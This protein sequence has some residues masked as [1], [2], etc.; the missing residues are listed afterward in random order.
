MAPTRRRNGCLQCPKPA[1]LNGIW[2]AWRIVPACCLD[3]LKT[4]FEVALLLLASA[5]QG[6]RGLQ[7]LQSAWTAYEH[8]PWRRLK[9]TLQ[10]CLQNG[11]LMVFE[12]C[13]QWCLNDATNGASNGTSNDAWKRCFQICLKGAWMVAEAHLKWHL[14]NDWYGTQS[15]L[16]DGAWNGHLDGAWT[17]PQM[18]PFECLKTPPEWCQNYVHFERLNGIL[19]APEIAPDFFCCL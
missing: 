13:L 5:A 14:N 4:T 9:M 11:A 12:W 16:E 1:L 15:A 6:R 2:N 8:R 7:R 17:V 19:T 3:R 10:W 18:V